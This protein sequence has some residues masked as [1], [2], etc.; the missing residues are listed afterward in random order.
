L[1]VYYSDRI[2]AGTLAAG[3][4]LPTE[5]EITL[6]HQVSRAVV[7]EALSQL[8]AAGLVETRQG[9]GTFVLETT[10]SAPFRIDPATVLTMRDVLALL[11]FRVSFET[12]SA[13]LAALR[14]SPAQLDR[15]LECVESIDRLLAAGNETKKADFE[16]HVA[17]AEATG[18]RYFSDLLVHLGLAILPRARVDLRYIAPNDAADYL[19]RSNREHHE[20]Y[21][22]ISSRDGE[23][24]RAAMRTHL[25]NS[26]DRLESLYRSSER[27]G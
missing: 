23:A 11:E 14:R 24:A 26:R 16:F 8:Q 3:A 20:I 25:N 4:K 17:I 21:Q 13:S 1:V 12:E 18:N 7:R 27:S 10:N 5:H 2:K 19:R 6:E 15:I 22:A 9:L